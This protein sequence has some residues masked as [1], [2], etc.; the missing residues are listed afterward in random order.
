M[1]PKTI[2]TLIYCIG[3]AIMLAIAY[4]LGVFAITLG[5]VI[6][7]LLLT[8]F[9]TILPGL[10][11]IENLLNQGLQTTT[12]HGFPTNLFLLKTSIQ[13]SA[14]RELLAECI[15]KLYL[16]PL[17]EENHPKISPTEWKP[18]DEIIK[19]LQPKETLKKP[20]L[21]RKTNVKGSTL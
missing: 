6:G 3:A 9:Q 8:H 19:R 20:N 7:T 15:R 21:R 10:Q 5:T 13:K 2:G 1:S 11:E 12:I 16:E 18:L 4:W 14:T 17:L